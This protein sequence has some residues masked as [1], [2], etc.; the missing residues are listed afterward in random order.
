MG[1]AEV[2][3][4]IL[5]AYAGIGVVFA[6]AFVTRGVGRIDHAAAGAPWSFRV[7]IFPGAAVLWPLLLAKWRH[8]GKAGNP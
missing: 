3:L 5:A 2:I 7:L 8:A 4:W 6:F 1:I